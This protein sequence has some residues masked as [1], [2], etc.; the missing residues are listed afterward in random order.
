MD[1]LTKIIYG[2]L[3]LVTDTTPDGKRKLSI[4]RAPLAAMLVT[5]VY[6]YITK[7][8]GP[9]NQVLAFIGLAMAYNGFGKSK[10]AGGSGGEGTTTAPP[11]E[12][13]SPD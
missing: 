1:K 3:P 12:G 7:G 11:V 8:V 6:N 4:G 13:A 5:M 10:A 9:D 2:I